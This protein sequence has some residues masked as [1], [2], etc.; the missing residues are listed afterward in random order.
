MPDLFRIMKHLEVVRKR[1]GKSDEIETKMSKVRKN[2]NEVIKTHKLI[3]KPDPK[4][5]VLN[6][7]N[8]VEELKKK[9]EE[10]EEEE[11]DDVQRRKKDE[12]LMLKKMN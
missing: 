7:I 5:K 12:Q 11:M 6:F 4:E 1:N 3:E 8:S 10:K 9:I 2:L